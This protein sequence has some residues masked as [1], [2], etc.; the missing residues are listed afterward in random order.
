L[1]TGVLVRYTGYALFCIA[2]AIYVFFG[3]LA[4]EHRE[5]YD[6]QVT[7]LHAYVY[8]CAVRGCSLSENSELWFT[9]KKNLFSSPII[10]DLFIAFAKLPV[11]AWTLIA[12]ILYLTVIFALT[13]AITRSAEIA[14]FA[15]LL[16]ATTPSFLYW[17]KY[18]VYGAYT[19]EFT[20]IASLLAWGYG[21]ARG[22]R[23]A[24]L[25]GTILAVIAWFLTANGWLSLIV[26]GIYLL[27]SVFKGVFSKE[28]LYPVIALLVLTLPLNTALGILYV[29]Q[30]H[31]FAYTLLLLSTAFYSVSHWLVNKVDKVSLKVFRVLAVIACFP[32]AYYTTLLASEIIGFP[33]VLENYARSYNPP[34][35]Y[36]ILTILSV[37]ALVSA[38][39]ERAGGELRAATP[40]ILIST[41]FITAAMLAYYIQVLAVIAS[42][43]A[44]PLVSRYLIELISKLK[45][46][47][48]VPGKAIHAFAAWLLIGSIAV[49]AVLSYSVVSKP[50]LVTY[51]DVP[52][53][54]VERILAE[55]SSFLKALDY[56]KSVSG[57]RLV[58][59]YWGY[60]YWIHSHL[61]AGVYT[62][63]DLSGPAEG[64]R[65]VSWIFLS[66]EETTFHLVK[67]V[68][69]SRNISVYVVVSEVVSLKQGE[70]KTV[71]LGAAILL[72]PLTP[73]SGPSRSYRVFGDLSRIAEYAVSGGFNVT[74]YLTLNVMYPHEYPLSWKYNTLNTLLVK[75]VI[76]GLNELGYDVVNSVYAGYPLA[77]PSLKYFKFVNATL[78]PLYN[79]NR[80]GYSY[81]VY[82]YTAVFEVDLSHG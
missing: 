2:V 67:N 75:L 11:N 38:L 69:G 35:D 59:S 31:G 3:Y 1:K 57:D 78:I 46:S 21:F 58:I 52:R 30:Y 79:V 55:E 56:I 13:L 47:N 8:N 71:D 32:I 68:V 5:V 65:L 81:T 76:R 14:G 12:G 72:P 39:R 49:G 10:L 51:V 48:L 23:R 20:I 40:T 15:S 18:N 45:T 7:W 34:L 60:S 42:A 82:S 36:G 24:L 6:D 66:D 62:L 27:I 33:G 70:N 50:P 37:F 74:D 9:A 17:F 54:L 80:Y 26:Y 29:T 73:T 77:K 43:S 28:S 25:T 22:S 16:L 19:T 4:V 53:E 44:S 64:W 63:S 61:G 41:S